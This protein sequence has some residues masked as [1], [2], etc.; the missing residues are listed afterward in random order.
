MVLKVTFSVWKMSFLIFDVDISSPYG[1][2]LHLC[3]NLK[4]VY[5]VSGMCIAV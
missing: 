1:M 2:L 4:D 5:Y 3:Y